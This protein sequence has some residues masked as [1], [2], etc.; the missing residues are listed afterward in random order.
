M[1]AIPVFWILLLLMEWIWYFNDSI[2]GATDR[3]LITITIHITLVVGA[4]L[5]IAV[6][7]R[8]RK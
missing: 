8:N 4:A 2:H 3:D 5:T 7:L 6:A 1:V